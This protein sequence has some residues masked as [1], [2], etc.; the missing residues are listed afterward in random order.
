MAGMTLLSSAIHPALSLSWLNIR[1]DA[2]RLETINH[3]LTSYRMKKNHLLGVM[4][5]TALIAA[6]CENEKQEQAEL[7]AQAKITRDQAQQTV[8]AQVPNGTIK[9]G[10][11]EKG[12]L[13]WSFDVTTPDSKDTTEVNVDALSGKVVSVDKESPEKEKNEKD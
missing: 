9:E 7:Q 5:A 11:L 3:Q 6:G 12:Q 10:E 8:L 2:F 1:A 4:L 13:I